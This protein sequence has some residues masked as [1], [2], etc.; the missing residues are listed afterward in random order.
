M[1]KRNSLRLLT[2]AEIS[3]AME[4]YGYAI[5]YSRVWVHHGSYLPFGMQEN[6]TAMTP[7]G[8]IWFETNVYRDDYSMSPVDF[9]HLFMHEM[10]HVWQYQRGMNVRMRGLVSWATDYK[11]DLTKDH[12]SLYSMEQQAS[13]VSDFW[14]LIKYG[15]SNY[16]GIIKYKDYD[17]SEPVHE[18]IAKYKKVLRSFPI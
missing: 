12:L 9:K 8:E 16:N 11:Y 5:E 6:N 2:S 13:I 15:Y 10:M 3:L 18:L 14:L 7:N 17:S 4:I 1:L